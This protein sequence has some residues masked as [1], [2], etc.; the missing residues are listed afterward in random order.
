[1]KAPRADAPAALSALANCVWPVVASLAVVTDNLAT[2]LLLEYAQDD[3]AP[4]VAAVVLRI[5]PMSAE[6]ADDVISAQADVADAPG[7][8][9]ATGTDRTAPPATRRRRRHSTR[10][11]R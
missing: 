6:A 8:V 11:G 9:G 7:R 2:A 3:V 5:V 10:L 1:M 4:A